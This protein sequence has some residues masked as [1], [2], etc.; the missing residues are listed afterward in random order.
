MQGTAPVSGT[1]PADEKLRLL[2]VGWAA[3]RGPLWGL[4][5]AASLQ[6]RRAPFSAPG[7]PAIYAA[8]VTGVAWM[9]SWQA[10]QTMSVLRRILAMSAAHAGCPGPGFPSWASLPT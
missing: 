10:S 4:F 6:T 1:F 3:R 8:C 9:C 5:R 7:F 2:G